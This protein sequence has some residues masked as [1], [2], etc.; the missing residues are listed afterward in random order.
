[1]GRR[2]QKI[3][4]WRMRKTE[5]GISQGKKGPIWRLWV[6]GSLGCALALWLGPPTHNIQ[7]VLLIENIQSSQSPPDKTYQCSDYVRIITSE[8]QVI[9]PFILCRVIFHNQ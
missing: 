6:L 8:K 9:D 7:L 3:E 2:V 1:M 5:A 4:H